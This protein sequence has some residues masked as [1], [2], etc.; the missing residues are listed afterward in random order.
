MSTDVLKII[1]KAM[2]DLGLNYQFDKWKGA[3]QYPYFT[4]EYSETEAA[5]ESGMQEATFILNGFSRST[6]D[7]LESAKALIEEYFNKIYG[8]TAIAK[9]GNA[10][11]VF[12]SNCNSIPVEDAE[13]KRIQINLTIK[14]WKVN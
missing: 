12:Y 4:G 14:E 8:F 1:N 6:W 13:L 3:P 7:A 10:V 11:A 2:D 5:S 9:S